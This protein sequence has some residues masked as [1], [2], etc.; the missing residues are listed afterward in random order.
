MLSQPI[1]WWSVK[2]SMNFMR[3]CAVVVFLTLFKH[4]SI[5]RTRRYEC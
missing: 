5:R 4:S 1:S 3:E 2:N